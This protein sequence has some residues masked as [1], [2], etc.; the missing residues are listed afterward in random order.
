MGEALIFLANAIS[1]GAIGHYVSRGLSRIDS[2]LPILLQNESDMAKIEAIIE[3]KGLS[4]EVAAFAEQARY[5]QVNNENVGNV[6]NFSGGSNYGYIANKIEVK[7]QKKQVRIEAPSGTIASSVIHRNYTKYLIDRYHKFK[8]E[9]VGKAKM[10]YA[11][12]YEAIKREFGAK[13]DHIQLSRFELVVSYIQQRIE[14]TV[15]GKNNKVNG[16]KSY[17]TF[18]E[19]CA[20]HGG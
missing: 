15:L 19:Y 20:K 14:R 2:E 9:D 13:W 5:H 12:F 1:S 4:G 11:V 7:N 6:V 18:T 8:K 16:K 10:N 3:S 17:S